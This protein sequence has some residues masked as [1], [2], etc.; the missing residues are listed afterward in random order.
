MAGEE[1]ATQWVVLE[2]RPLRVIEVGRE[3]LPVHRIVYVPLD[4]RARRAAVHLDLH[5]SSIRVEDGELPESAALDDA[6][7]LPPGYRHRIAE[8]MRDRRETIETVEGIR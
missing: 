8:R 1:Q 4:D 6:R 2:E 7:S 5:G 3:D